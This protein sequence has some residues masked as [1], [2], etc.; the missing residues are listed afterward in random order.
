M[1]M[2]KKLEPLGYVQIITCLP[3]FFM[4]FLGGNHLPLFH[5]TV[6][7]FW[8]ETSF[9]LSLL[10]SIF[11]VYYTKKGIPAGFLRF[12]AFF[13]PYLLINLFCLLYTWNRFSTIRELNTMVWVLG[14]VYLFL[15]SEH[16]DNFIKALLF[17]ASLSVLCMIVQYKFLFPGLLDVFKDSRY[18]SIIKEKVVPFSSFLNEAT[19]GGYF[20]FLI[21]V[22]IY[23][24][25]LQKKLLYMILSSIII[26]GLF[27]S[28]SRMGMLLGSLS[29]LASAVVVYKKR[30]LKG[31]VVLGLVILF[32][33]SIFLAV[34]YGG[35]RQSN[36]TLQGTAI[37]KLKK[38]PEHITTLTYRT[39]TWNRSV[40]AFMDKPLI[41]YG[42]GAF[43]YAYRKY[44]DAT[45][46]TRYAHNILVKIAV[47]LGI[48]GLICFLIYLLGFTFGVKKLIKETKYLFIFL[49]VVS[50]FL[51]SLFNVTFEM[52]AYMTTFFI[53]S[54]VF[55]V[56]DQEKIK[57]G[58]NLIFLS[59]IAVLLGSF[60]FTAK[61]DVSQK[62]I[63][64]GLVYEENRLFSQAIVSYKEAVDS[65]PLNNNGYVGIMSIL[66]KS[67]SMEQN[68]HERE[69]MRDMIIKYLSKID[70]NPDKD[71]ELFFISGSAHSLL[72][73]GEEAERYLG[74]AMRYHPSSGYYM[75][76]TANFYFLHGNTEKADLLVKRMEKY[77]DRHVGSDM[78]GL[79]VY[80]MRDLQSNI[81]YLNGHKENALRLARRNLDDAE[82][83]KGITEN[84]RAR[85][86]V[87]KESFIKYFR[88][89]VEFYE[90][91]SNPSK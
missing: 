14:C 73:E 51:F 37:Y 62:L 16:K 43:E 69:R 57:Q 28:L 83:E 29:I 23:F 76:E 6:D 34:V 90:S 71:S 26:F 64:D 20:L 80:K 39:G 8:I 17:G 38:I 86:Y 45:L 30:G 11:L 75:Y 77:S 72:G 44:Y 88:D 65:M 32:A 81:E 67:Y 70:S 50:G 3:F 52:P 5:F 59:V 56:R 36:L 10:I 48:V 12:L 63:E 15:E 78:H 89:K 61:A 60:F 2:L 7:K 85:E 82:N 33:S 40:D 41:G 31:V 46:Y 1:A 58:A 55:F 13:C 21:P 66:I 47:E 84:I 54:S 24:A 35:N 22:S 53:L 9:V 87:M 27:F 4:P 19:L 74:E 25:V 18:T 91:K 79:Y 42:A 68:L 49:S